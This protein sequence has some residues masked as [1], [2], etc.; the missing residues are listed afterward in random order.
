[1][2]IELGEI[3]AVLAAHPRVGEVAV[4]A[5]EDRPG[6]RRLVAYVV[7]APDS[8]AGR[9]AAP[10]TP[11]TVPAVPA[12][13]SRRTARQE[14]RKAALPSNAVEG[15]A[16]PAPSPQRAARQEGQEASPLSEAA[17]GLAVP[18]PSVKDAG[19]V[20]QGASSGAGVVEGG[21]SGVS[22]PQGVD[23]GLV[24]ELRGFVR[25]RLPQYMVP[26]AVVVLGALPLTGN[27][28]LD[29]AALPA[30][31]VSGSAAGPVGGREAL[32][33][34]L[35]AE[36]LGMASVGV[37]DGFFDLG[38][39][40]ILAIQLVAR[41]RAAGL[42][43]AP[44]DV[45]RHQ[46]VR[47]LALV[48]TE[49]EGVQAEP[50]GAGVGP[51]RPTPIMQWLAEREGPADGFNQTVV[52]RVPPD[53]GSDHLTAALQAVLD[54]HDALRLSRHG[55]GGLE[56]LP[57]GSVRADE[58]VRRVEVGDALI[59]ATASDEGWAGVVAEQAA[60]SRTRL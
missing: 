41:A 46:S 18:A 40:S 39:D 33:C 25:G 12:P 47:E 60:W 31:R 24:E 1:F 26:S 5:R 38:G 29:R 14:G 56:V 28:K 2:R 44:K 48:A 20:G 36:V 34:G 27:G 11:P 52:L 30:P 50:E 45:F 51:V 6:D 57:V 49:E 58:C 54:R 37:E 21:V 15:T 53:L 9:T 3:E 19:Q 23:E 4:L 55:A 7:P 10:T 35:F 16:V 42:M 43:F 32:L 22:L 17:E 59:A 8:G 13:S